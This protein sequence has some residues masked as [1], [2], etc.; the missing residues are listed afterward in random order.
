M[1]CRP[2][3]AHPGPVPASLGM[4]KG[5]VLQP[6]G[7]FCCF[8]LDT[9]QF[10]I[11]PQYGEAQVLLLLAASWLQ[12]SRDLKEHLLLPLSSTSLYTLLLQLGF[13][14]TLARHESNSTGL[15]PNMGCA[16][17]TTC[18]G[19][20]YLLHGRK[21]EQSAFTASLQR[22][23]NTA[24]LQSLTSPFFATSPALAGPCGTAGQGEHFPMSWS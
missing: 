8:S 2:Q 22:R 18:S 9:C 12:S 11:P 23:Q 15:P 14:L 10:S 21:G 3:P 19:D 1:R 4:G 7:Y 6:H 20:F 16:G 5:A 24:R 13:L 17:T